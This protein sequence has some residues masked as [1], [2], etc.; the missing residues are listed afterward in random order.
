M[1]KSA[2]VIMEACASYIYTYGLVDVDEDDLQFRINK[3]ITD[4]LGSE[5]TVTTLCRTFG[6]SR[7]AI[8][9]FFS[10]AYGTTVQKFIFSKRMQCAENLLKNSSASISEI[11]IEVGIKD[12]NYFIK[13]FKKHFGISPLKFRKTH[14]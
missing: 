6:L 12:Y 13:V 7:A 14:R 5:L 3:Y 8:Y 9:E 4:N 11:A 10:K 2:S 1:T